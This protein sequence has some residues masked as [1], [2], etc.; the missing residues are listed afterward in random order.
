MGQDLCA[1]EIWGLNIKSSKCRNVASVGKLLWQLA[2]KKDVLWVKWVH[3]LFMKAQPNIWTHS[4]PLD[5]SWYWKKLN[6]IKL[7]TTAWYL[8]D[9][10]LQTSNGT[11][12]VGSSYIALKGNLTRLQ[13]ADLIWSRVMQPKHRVILWL[14]T[15]SKLL[16][17]DRT[18]RMTIPVGDA[19]CCLCDG[20]LNETHQHLFVDYSWIKEVRDTLVTWTGVTGQLQEVQLCL[21]GYSPLYCMPWF[22]S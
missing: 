22:T 11:Y 16:T 21:I 20:L 2:S 6:T 8:N 1:K 15:R 9:T 18:A 19:T 12:S 14:V 17:E 5:R 7:D 13:V 3:V 4:P 10:D